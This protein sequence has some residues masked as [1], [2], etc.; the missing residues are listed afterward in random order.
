M[1]LPEGDVVIVGSGVAGVSAAIPLVEAG[2]NVV[3]IDG[4][5]DPEQ[6]A[7]SGRLYDI[8][9][10]V[11]DQWKL[12][13]GKQ[14]Q[15]LRTDLPSSPKFRAPTNAFAYHGYKTT[16]HVHAANFS[17]VG[18]LA[19]GGLSNVWGAGV[20][21]YTQEELHDFP[22]TRADLQP[23]YRAIAARIGVSG[24][25]T[26]DLASFFGEDMPLQPPTVLGENAARLFRR[27]TENPEPAQRQ[28]VTLGHARNAVL[29]EDLGDRQGCD[30]ANLCIWGCARRA[31]YS[32]LYDLEFLKRHNNFHYGGKLILESLRPQSNGYLLPIRPIESASTF[33]YPAKVIILACGA[34]GSAKLVLQALEMVDRDIPFLSAPTAGFALWLPER[35]GAAVSRKAFGL[36]QLSYTVRGDRENS[37]AFGNLF[38]SDGLLTSE[39]VR[40]LPFSRPSAIQFMQLLGPSLLLGNCFLPGNFSDHTLVFRSDGALQIRGGYQDS[41]SSF[42]TKIKRRLTRAFM[43]Y[44]IVTLP[45]SFK[46]TAPGEDVHYAA[47]V[48]MRNVPEPHQAKPTGEVAGLGNVYVVDGA[49]LTALP[50][51][52]HTFTIM[53]NA[54]RI[55]RGLVGRLKGNGGVI[56]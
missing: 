12:F 42:M 4:G 17:I 51:K 10:R 41:L 33:E 25:V 44:G 40:Y 34:I 13:V 2:L 47:T 37:L 52:G 48:P 15:A 45:N 32:A 46:L 7:P 6:S 55:A 18:S 9:T 53:A 27:Y 26:D 35:L 38:G 29:T 23:S 56:P 54:D 36:G 50:A 31:I 14:F 43:R 39:F 16:Y 5:I 8:R 3:M 20:S 1:K 21:C 19:A 22:L 28:G 11:A 24:S 30:E 49:A